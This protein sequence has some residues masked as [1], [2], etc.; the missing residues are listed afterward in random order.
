MHCMICVVC[1]TFV[2]VLGWSNKGIKTI[3]KDD[4]TVDCLSNHLTSFA[5]LV[6]LSVQVFKFVYFLLNMYNVGIY[7]TYSS[8]KVPIQS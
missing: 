5:V 2:S 7:H 6:S 8:R 4:G 1:I 3:V